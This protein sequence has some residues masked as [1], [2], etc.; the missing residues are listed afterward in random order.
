MSNSDMHVRMV[1]H[2][3]EQ[4]VQDALA[5]ASYLELDAKGK[6][7]VNATINSELS[8]MIAEDTEGRYAWMGGG[9]DD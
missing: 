6:R 9:A 4:K 3:S 8:R 7:A 2:A 1:S 5:I